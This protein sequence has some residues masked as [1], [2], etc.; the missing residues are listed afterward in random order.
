MRTSLSRS[1]PSITRW[2]SLP[3]SVL[4]FYV[5]APVA[6][7]SVESHR[8]FLAS[9]GMVGRVY[10]CS[11]ASTRGSALA[12]GEA[13]R[14]L[15]GTHFSEQLLFKEDPIEEPPSQDYV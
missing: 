15:Q 11:T 13:Y 3:F 12:I 2:T 1:C 7:E 4:A 8:A 6:D 5:I 9:R 10:V 14:A